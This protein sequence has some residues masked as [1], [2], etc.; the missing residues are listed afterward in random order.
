[1]RSS[2]TGLL[3][4]ALL[5]IGGAALTAYLVFSP[6]A[7]FAP[8]R[9]VSIHKGDSMTAAARKL[10]QA[11]VV[12]SEVAFALYAK[13]TGRAKRVKPGDYA[14]KGGE[15][16]PDVLTHLVNGDFMVVTIT[17]PEGITVR[18]IGERFAAAGLLCENDFDTAA[19][20]GPIVSAL[21]LGPLGAE[22]FLFPATYRFSPLTSTDH[23]LTA[24]LGRFFEA[25]TPDVEQRLF[26]LNLSAREMVTMASIIE[27]EAHSPDERPIIASVFYNRLRLGMPL[28]S[29]PTAQY[30]LSG[31][32]ER[33]AA[34]VRIPSA[35]NTYE[36]A[37]LPPGPIANPGL[38]SM[39]A[40]LYPAHTDYLYFVAR[41][42]GTHIF[43]RS[44]AEHE[45]AIAE[46]KE[47]RGGK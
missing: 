26:D 29:D 12:Q 2:T 27:K 6:T 23:I 47:M 14:F 15:A 19:R 13:V 18:Q 1:L 25:L 45:H 8:P 36:I 32:S 44:F 20:T 28:Q 35:F 40:A 33:A 22:G 11:G 17:I 16:M 43:S 21:G 30:N 42:D 34:A 5:L 38:P 4:F 41:N 7:A 39:R 46:V 10:A 31:E 9:V 37:G 24:M 3:L